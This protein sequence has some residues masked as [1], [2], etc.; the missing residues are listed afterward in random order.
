MK[1][2]HRLLPATATASGVDRRFLD[3]RGVHKGAMLIFR[4]ESR[5]ISRNGM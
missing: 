1:Y 4:L 3:N 5:T 2:S